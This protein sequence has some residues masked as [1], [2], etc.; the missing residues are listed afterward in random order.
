MSDAVRNAVGKLAAGDRPSPGE[1]GS[2]FQA[3]L[4]GQAE[5]ALIAAFLMGLRIRGETVE[6]IVAGV[7]VMRETMRP[8]KAPEDAID[9]C[10]TGGLSWT[11]L[12]TSTAVALVAAGAGVVVAKH[13]NRAITSKSGT[14]DVL[15]ALGVNIDPGLDKQ[16][17][18]LDQAGICFLFAQAHH[19]AMRHVSP[20]RAELGFRTIFNLLGPLTNPAGAKRQVVGVFAERWVAPLA[21][22]LGALGSERAWVVHGGGMDE[23]TTTGETSV[24]E[25]RDGQVRLFTVTPEAVGLKRSALADLTGATI[26]GRVT[27]GRGSVIGGNNSNTFGASTNIITL[28]DTSG[29]ADASVTFFNTASGYA[30]PI[31]VASGSTGAATIFLGTTSGGPV[32]SGGITLNKDLIIAKEGTSG[33]SSISGGITGTGNVIISNN[34][35][36]GTITLSTTSVNQTGTITNSGLAT[37]STT[38]SAVIGTNVTGVIQNS[39]TSSLTLGAVANLWTTGLTI[40]A[41]TVIGG[42]NANTFGDNANI[43]TIGDSSGA[44]NA[45]LQ[46]TNSLTYLQPIT[47]ASGNTGVATLILGT[48][49][50]SAIW[51]GAVTLNSHDLTIGKTGTTGSAQFNGGITGTGN[52]TINN[53]ATTTATIT[54]GTSALNNIGTITNSG[55]ATGA[56]IFNADIGSN[57]TNVIQ[58]SATSALT[59]SSANLNFGTATVSLGT[60]NITGSTAAAPSITNLSVAAGATFNTLNTV[61]Q[62]LSLTSLNL[63]AGIGAATLGMEL[64]STSNYD[65][66]ALTG[67]ATVVN[68]VSFRLTGLTGFGPGVYT[69]LSATSGLSAANYGISSVSSLLTGSSFILSSTDSLV[70]LTA[71]ASTGDFYWKG[72]ANTSWS[73]FS[74]ITSNFTSDLAGSSNIFG[75]P[76]ANSS[77]IFSANDLTITSLSTTLDAAFNIK[78]LT[79]NS[80]VGTGPLSAITIAAGTGGSLTLTPTASTSGINLQ[81]GAPASVTISAPLVLAAA[82]SWTVADATTVLN[83]S[84][85]VTGNGFNLTKLGD[86][87]LQL[88]TAN[89]STYNGTTTITGGILRAG[90]AT[91]FSANS[92]VVIGAA[93]K[94]QLNGFNNTIASLAGVAGAIVENGSAATGATLTVGADNT[95]TTFAGV[96]QNGGAANL[97]LV[98]TG[99]GALTLSGAS[100]Y[101]GNTTVSNGTLNITGSITGNTTTTTLVYGSTANNTV[102]NVSGNMTLFAITG[103]NIAGGAAVYNQTAGTVNITPGTGNIQYVAKAAGSYGYF[104]LTG[105][106][107]IAGNRFDVNGSSNLGSAL[108]FATSSAGVVYVGGTGFLDHTNAEW[109]INGYSLGQITVADSGV[110]D[111]TGSSASFAIFMDSTT[112]GGAY[113]VL[114]LAGGT[115]ITG[116][117]PV[118]FGNSTTN[119]NGNVGFVNLAAGTLS[120][121]TAS[122]SSVNATGAN[123]AYLNFAG[124]TLKTT[125]AITNWVPASTTGI[126]YTSTFF[127]AID[128]STVSGAPSFTGGLVFDSGGFNSSFNQPFTAATGVGVTQSDMTVVGGTGYI[129]APAVVFS[130]AGLVAGGTPAAGYALISGGAVTGIVITSPGTYVSG[131]TPTLTLT[132]GG[133][134]GAS[135]TLGALSTANTSGGLTKIGGGTL[136]L[137][138]ANTYTGGTTVTGGT[139]ALGASNALAATGSVTVNGGTFDLT[140]FNNTVASFTLQSGTITGTTGVLTSTS[141]FDLRSGTVNAILSGSV[142]VT[143]T[144]PG[145]VTL[146]STSTFS[147]AVN[148]NGGRLSFATSGNLGNASATNTLGINGGT[149]DRKSVV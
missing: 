28:G 21:Q 15:A 58:N 34:A 110:I 66:I 78:D 116:A 133:G 119:D 128:N 63:G 3:I 86:G 19:G 24:A 143:K 48:G 10:G 103:G 52:V 104:N 25:Y 93:G 40:K 65:T 70:Q 9:T 82:Q 5:P 97:A 47:V 122:V 80:N 95:S 41:G 74:G 132:G 72:A 38:I 113:G 94:L 11:S 26:L 64:G 69:L 6:D 84:G 27:I 139:L 121:G 135:V 115:V 22:V 81:T 49:T 59:L 141:N 55:T 85:G 42:N 123:N 71:A 124:G 73:G 50:G 32:L 36:T 56:T 18:A 109:F 12:N 51:N 44:L 107:F 75:T 118:R 137:S 76:G 134:T 99:T 4:A 111:H 106:T 62:T 129:G 112:V 89:A 31:V 60:L 142:G 2:A 138:A 67:A 87:I 145:T 146:N 83:V 147:G 13:G 149:L 126:T 127:G 125:A 1:I 29:S 39:L 114:N 79:F 16:R 117:Q 57:V 136:T 77:V 92:A 88:T 96:L 35:T 130:S 17:A 108:N 23:M 54:I 144:T 8:A 46:V 148:A 20:I 102:V 105:G 140:T 14:A 120:V 101:L 7:R 43:L 100:T 30:N 131:T 91:A 90:S 45:T 53:T 61:G 37:G 33:S 68:A 98:K